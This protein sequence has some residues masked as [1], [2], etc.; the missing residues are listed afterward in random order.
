MPESVSTKTS[1]H[2]AKSFDRKPQPRDRQHDSPGVQGSILSL[3]HA[4]GNQA[5]SELLRLQLDNSHPPETLVQRH[6]LPCGSPEDPSF[7][8]DEERI[9]LDF[10][11]KVINPSLCSD[12][13]PRNHQKGEIAAS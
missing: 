4:V 2:E 13:W 7:K 11:N 9:W 10:E 6:W 12:D 8:C 3:Q 5:V 1:K